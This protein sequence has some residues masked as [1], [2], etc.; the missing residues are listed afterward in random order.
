MVNSSPIENQESVNSCTANAVAKACE[1]Y[2]TA[3]NA[4]VHL[5]R[6]FNYFESRQ[7]DGLLG[8]DA[9]AYLRTAIAAA[10]Q[11]G[12]PEETLWPYIPALINTTPASPAFTDAATKKLERYELIDS[13]SNTVAFV[14]KVKSA[15]S[16]GFPV[17]IGFPLSLQFENLAGN[18]DYQYLHPYE[19][20]TSDNPE[21]GA[22][23]GLLIGYDNAYDAFIF[24]NSW[25]SGWGYGGY[26]LFPYSALQDIVEAWV[27]RGFAGYSIPPPSGSSLTTDPFAST[28]PTTPVDPVFYFQGEYFMAISSTDLV[29]RKSALVS[30]STPSANGGKVDFTN[31]ITTNVKNNL[32]PDVSQAERLAGASANRKLFL[33][34]NKNS[35]DE[36]LNARISL[37]GVTPAGD[38]TVFYAGTNTDT[39][40]TTAFARPYGV[41]LSTASVASSDTA[42]TIAPEDYTWAL[43]NPPFVDGDT[44]C[45]SDG[46]N[47]EYVPVT[48]VDFSSPNINLS[49][50]SGLVHSYASGS[51]VAAVLTV[52]STKAA[53]TASTV[54]SSAGVYTDASNLLVNDKG[55]TDEAWTLTFTS[56]TTYTVAG[57]VLGSV[58]TGATT[59]DCTITNTSVSAPYFVVKAS[60]FSGTWATGNTLQF[61]TTSATIPLWLRR[62]VP[63]GCADITSDYTSLLVNAE[64]F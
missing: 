20:I 52:A 10:K 49:L 28:V 59:A 61:T 44:V 32:F 45:I 24:E 16:E 46:T 38:F 13:A 2:L 9:G 43:A 53:T 22:H 3:N 19:G 60:G 23:A 48:T 8:S 27:L 56:A 5:S 25:G 15:I 36:L 35:G 50:G 11:V 29:W 17:A 57:A 21:I 31:T 39:E 1:M 51:V 40:A 33:H 42:I 41:G 62:V 63:A 7:A 37:S 34:V 58:G 18:F 55:T 47:T 64:S 30:V 54:T 6:M 14:T 4:F 26:C 12:M